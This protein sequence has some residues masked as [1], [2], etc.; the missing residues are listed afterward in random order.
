VDHIEVQPVLT[1]H[2]DRGRGEGPVDVAVGELVA[3]VRVVG[4]PRLVH[5]WRAGSH[6][7]Q[8]V[9]HR[10]S[11]GVLDL[12]QL[13]RGLGD[14][15]A[16]GRHRGHLVAHA[17][18]VVG[19]ERHLVPGEAEGMLLDVGPGEHGQH[20]RQRRRAPG[21]DAHDARVR[22]ARAEDLAVGETGQVQVVQVAGAAGD[23]VR[24]VALG[25]RPSDDGELAH[26]VVTL[27]PASP[28]ARARTAC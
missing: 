8:R 2:H 26:A 28:P 11:L 27:R 1:L 9:E 22:M 5:Q 20:A 3:Q 15:R 17:A 12:D 23:L 19:L 25:H 16:L 13:Q 14:G 18:G 21:V 10:R 7:G 6:R 24:P 4:R